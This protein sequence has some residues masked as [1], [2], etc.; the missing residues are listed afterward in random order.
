[1]RFSVRIGRRERG[2]VWKLAVAAAVVVSGGCV[3][4]RPSDAQLLDQQAGNAAAINAK[5][6]GDAT[7]A[8]EL[9]SWWASDA[10]AWKAVADWANGRTPAPVN[11]SN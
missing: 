8:P 3:V 11:G 5:V 7:V 9:R 2:A 1:M 6:Q 10:T 4:V